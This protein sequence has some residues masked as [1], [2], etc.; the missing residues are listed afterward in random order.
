MV[1][2]DNNFCMSNAK[3][4]TDD[5]FIKIEPRYFVD[6]MIQNATREANP[7]VPYYTVEEKKLGNETIYGMAQCSFD[8]SQTNC[9]KCLERNNYYF[10]RCF[11]NKLGGR[12]LGRSCSF[13]F[14]YYPFLFPKAGPKYLKP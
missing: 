8:M 6:D 2:Y 9:R 12:V 14:E 11:Y 3:N 10:R 5:L 7:K 13:R 1:D 4:L